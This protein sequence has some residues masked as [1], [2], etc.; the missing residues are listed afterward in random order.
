MDRY[1]SPRRRARERQEVAITKS[2]EKVRLDK[3]L[4]AARFYKTRSAASKAVAGGKVQLNGRRP[5]PSSSV[6]R[7]D[8]IRVRKGQ[9]EYEVVVR[10]LAERRGSASQAAALYE[11]T[12]ESQERR[13][14][15]ALQRKAMP[16]FDF[17][18]GGRPTK[19]ERRA[20]ERLRGYRK[21]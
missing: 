10:D 6:T 13:E 14:R 20:L 7:D 1:S 19:K 16:R 5:K 9:W 17:R 18:E 4:W 21:K 15:H 11:E 3:W 12:Q 8:R 2:E